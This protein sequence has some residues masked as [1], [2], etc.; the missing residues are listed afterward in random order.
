MNLTSNAMESMPGGGII[1]MRT[2]NQYIDRPIKGYDEVQEGDYAVFTIVDQGEGISAG[3]IERIFEPFYTKKKM[4]KSGTG[5]GMAVVWGTVKDHHGYINVQS[6][7]GKGS[8]FELYFPV[9]RSELPWKDSAV[10]ME[11]YMGRGESILVVDDI[12]EQRE[13]ASGMLK[14]LGYTVRTVSSGEAAVDYLKEHS[15]D[16]VILDMI[17]DPGMSGSETYVRILELH[18]G[19]KA[20]IASGYSETKDVKEAQSLGAG[21]YLRKPYKLEI[22]GLAVKVELEN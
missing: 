15:V 10:L 12:E 13:I 5:L 6:T 14:K 3:D 11:Q 4:G 7:A 2:R 16:L 19:Q 22:L 9:T 21:K 8:L 18:P 17:M 1:A 20:I